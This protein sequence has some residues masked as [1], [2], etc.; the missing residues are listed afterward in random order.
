MTLKDDWDER[1]RSLGPTKKAVLFKRFPNWLNNK[2]HNAHIDFILS[3]VSTRLETNI[4]DVGCGYGRV[5]LEI[6]NQNPHVSIEGVELSSE[7]SQNYRQMIGPCF[8]GSIQDYSPVKSFDHII[9][10]TILMYID[11]N[12]LGLTVD[13]LLSMLKPNGTLICIE[14][15]IEFQLIWRK[16]TKRKNASATGGDVTYFNKADLENT[17]TNQ[18]KSVKYQPIKLAPFLPPVHHAFSI[19]R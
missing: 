3:N 4:L 19:K 1:A 7:F 16:L 9:A 14:P 2:I 5:S 12:K 17:L 18:F 15:A 10:V 13:K 11:K 8:C 6:Q